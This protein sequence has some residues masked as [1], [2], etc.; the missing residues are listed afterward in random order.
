L[1]RD[2]AKRVLRQLSFQLFLVAVFFSVASAGTYRD[3][4]YQKGREGK[5]IVAEVVEESIDGIKTRSKLSFNPAGI[6]RVEYSD[7]PQGFIEGERHREQGRY[8][9]AVRYYRSA[10]DGKLGRRFWVE[11]QCRYWIAVCHLE[12]GELDKAAAAFKE[13]LGKH[14]KTRLLPDAL[15]ARG[16]VDYAGKKYAAAATRFGELALRAASS[17]WGEEWNYRAL[18][19]KAR[20]LHKGKKADLALKTTET[21]VQSTKG[22]KRHQD[23]SIEAETLEATIYVDEKRF[24]EGAELLRGLIKRIRHRVADELKAG[25]GTRMQRTEARCYNALGKC[26]LEQSAQ[27]KD[28]GDVLEAWLWFLR[29]VCLYQTLHDE[30]AEALYYAAL[31]FEKLGGTDEQKRQNRKRAEELRN[32][33]TGKH[34]DSPY[35]RKIAPPR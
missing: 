6:S 30:H 13:L 11:P 21:V 32:D 27:T 19:W 24:K 3:Q 8:D 9:E 17:N 31:C 4:I 12:G 15:L 23:I 5:P 29:T 1:K 28:R 25:S 22:E 14:P 35:A 26:Y 7:A 16:R 33:L 34:P 2:A 10:L 20:S 18:L